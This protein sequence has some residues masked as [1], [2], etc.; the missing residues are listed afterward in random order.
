[1]TGSSHISAGGSEIGPLHITEVTGSGPD[2]K[3]RHGSIFCACPDFPRVFL[4]SIVV[5]QNV[6]LCMIDMTTGLHQK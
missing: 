4:L 5:V 2:R 1:M 6:P 3:G